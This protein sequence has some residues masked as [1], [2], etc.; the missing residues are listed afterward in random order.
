MGHCNGPNGQ[1]LI[2]GPDKFRA[3]G[4][5]IR[6]EKGLRCPIIVTRD[7]YYEHRI[8]QAVAG[9]CGGQGSPLTALYIRHQGLQPLPHIDLRVAIDARCGSEFLSCD[10]KRQTASNLLRRAFLPE[11]RLD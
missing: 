3:Q 6:I 8:G 7:G 4:H 1:Q 11:C 10:Q 9:E 2:G 5:D